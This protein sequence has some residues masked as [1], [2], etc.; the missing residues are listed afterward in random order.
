MSRF[1][2]LIRLHVL[3]V[4]TSGLGFALR[5]FLARV[6][7]RPPRGTVLRIGPHLVDTLLLA[8]G[9]ALWIEAVHSPFREAW[10]GLKLLLVLAYIA[11]GMA[12]FRIQRRDRAVLA[13]LAALA[14]FV[15]IA[16]L[17]VY[18]PF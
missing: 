3:L 11:L 18:K 13:Y 6:L 1:D 10:F 4:L 8:S 17:A 9:I 16:T 7:D 14:V 5:G 15:A 2:V 12:A